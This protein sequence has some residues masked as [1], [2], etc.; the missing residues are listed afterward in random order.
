LSDQQEEQPRGD[1]FEE[2]AEPLS[3]E[4]P[5]LEPEPDEPAKV[6]PVRGFPAKLS[7]RMKQ[8]H[9]LLGIEKDDL[10]DH[11]HTQSRMNDLWTRIFYALD[12]LRD[13]PM[14]EK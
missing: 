12:C 7:T 10:G 9:R 11:K 14:E 6:E 1:F 13:C 3:S 5:E 8:M 2:P 4:G